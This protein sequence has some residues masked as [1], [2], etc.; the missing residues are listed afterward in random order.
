MKGKIAADRLE[1]ILR[2]KRRLAE[3]RNPDVRRGLQIAIY[4]LK[5]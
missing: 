1:V 3:E 4:E 2:L 5:E